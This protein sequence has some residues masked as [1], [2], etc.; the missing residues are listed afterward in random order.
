[1]NLEECL[2]ESDDKLAR[3][4]VKRM[5]KW[6]A[7]PTPKMGQVS[8]VPVPPGAMNK[9]WNLHK[10]IYAYGFERTIGKDFVSGWNAH[11]SDPYNRG[12]GS[13]GINSLMGVNG[14]GRRGKAIENLAKKSSS[15]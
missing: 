7:V 14:V 11:N 4:L 5:Q 6:V 10:A 2:T 13:R 1:M 15:V 9:I 3:A 8:N 12:A